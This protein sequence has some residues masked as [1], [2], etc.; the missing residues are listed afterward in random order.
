MRLIL[1]IK[2]GFV[3]MCFMTAT[4]SSVVGWYM[5]DWIK[6]QLNL[7]VGFHLDC[8]FTYPL[9]GNY[10][11]SFKSNNDAKE[12]YITVAWDNVKIKLI[13]NGQKVVYFISREEFA[14]TELGILG[15]MVCTFKGEP[16]KKVK[17]FQL[18]TMGFNV[19]NGSFSL[20]GGE[21]FVLEEQIS[22][23]DCVVDLRKLDNYSVSIN[24]YLRNIKD[25]VFNPEL[26]ENDFLYT[27]QED[28]GNGVYMDISCWLL[29]NPKI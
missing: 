24:A 10:H 14:K 4:Q 12:Y 7:P 27:K 2:E 5:G 15:H 20:K 19:F 26:K 25:V 22:K 11:Y 13:R 29:P 1:R 6:N 9:D 3:A 28:I 21:N 17:M 23:D 8:H 16:L 18:V